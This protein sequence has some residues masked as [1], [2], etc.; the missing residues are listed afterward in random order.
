[1]RFPAA[2]VAAPASVRSRSIRGIR[3]TPAAATRSVRE[4]PFTRKTSVTGSETRSRGGDSDTTWTARRRRVD[5]QR[6]LDPR[7]AEAV[8]RLDRDD[9]GA[10]RSL[11]EAL[12]AVPR[13]D[14][15]TRTDGRR[16]GCRDRLAVA[17]DAHGERRGT[18]SGRRSRTVSP[19]PSRLG[20]AQGRE[21]DLPDR[22]GDHGRECPRLVRPPSPAP[23]RGRGK[24][25]RAARRR[26]MRGS[27]ARRVA[28]GA[29]EPATSMPAARH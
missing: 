9:V 6:E 18:V 26:R 2:S 12:R 7:S 19:L 4:A 15:L 27:A 3:T 20:A 8:H 5:E 10:V 13:G 14:M 29:T 25:R 11:P 23:R 16:E 22:A 28:S 1:M 17:K 21:H 24:R